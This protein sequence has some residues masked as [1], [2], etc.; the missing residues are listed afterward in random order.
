MAYTWTNGEVITAQKL[1]DTGGN[2]YDFVLELNG[3]TAEYSAVG[4]SVSEL[5]EMISSKMHINATYIEDFIQSGETITTYNN[6]L[7]IS[8]YTQDGAFG[9]SFGSVSG[10]GIALLTDGTA[11]ISQH[12]YTFVYDSATKTYTFTPSENS[13]GATDDPNP[14]K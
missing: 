13:G 7:E 2:E 3:T 11:S 6:P 12:M 1:N 14:G 8:A 5:Y 10:W 9:V 4:K